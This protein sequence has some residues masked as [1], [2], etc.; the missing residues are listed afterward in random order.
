MGAFVICPFQSRLN[1]IAGFSVNPMALAEMQ[2]SKCLV[3]YFITLLSVRLTSS[4]LLWFGHVINEKAKQRQFFQTLFVLLH[5]I[6]LLHNSELLCGLCLR[7]NFSDTLAPISGYNSITI[8]INLDDSQ[9]SPPARLSK[10]PTFPWCLTTKACFGRA[11]KMGQEQASVGRGRGG[12]TP[13]PGSLMFVSF[14]T[15]RKH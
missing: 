15:S 3:Q 7:G 13:K 11:V 14:E 2:L 12:K 10:I 1:E 8:S 6:K 5:K 9:R 4:T